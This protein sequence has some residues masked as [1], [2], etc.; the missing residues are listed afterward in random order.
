MEWVV[1]KEFRHGQ[2]RRVKKRLITA[3]LDSLFKI[4][5]RDGG[6]TKAIRL[7][8]DATLG[9]PRR[10]DGTR[11]RFNRNI[12]TKHLALPKY[13]KP[14]SLFRVTEAQSKKKPRD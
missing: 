11:P 13:D 8:L 14:P 12:Y 3:M 10:A 1:V 2:V 9:K 5:I 7:Y 6:N 4:A